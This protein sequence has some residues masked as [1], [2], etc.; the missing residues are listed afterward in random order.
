L[1]FSSSKHPPSLATF[2][3]EFVA[4]LNQCFTQ[5]RRST[6]PFS[7]LYNGICSSSVPQPSLYPCFPPVPT[8]PP[9]KPAPPPA[10]PEEPAR[11]CL[12]SFPG[13]AHVLQLT[14]PTQKTTDR[15]T[16][17]KNEK[18]H[19]IEENI[20]FGLLFRLFTG[21]DLS[22]ARRCVFSSAGFA[23]RHHGRRSNDRSNR[24]CPAITNQD[25]KD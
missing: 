25:S 6:L 23:I 22:A 3:L 10:T 19:T 14:A 5:P 15:T 24:S 21:F 8:A 9:A 18:E 11:A 2:D 12:S 13:S 4:D 7:L 20:A 1:T 16:K 17:R